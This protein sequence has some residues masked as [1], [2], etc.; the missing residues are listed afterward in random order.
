VLSRVREAFQ[1]DLSLRRFFANP[2]ILDQ[3]SAVED[4]M[5]EEIKNMPDADAAGE[6]AAVAAVADGR[7]L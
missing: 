4:A 6:V 1:V 2:T 5:M 3:A 7:F